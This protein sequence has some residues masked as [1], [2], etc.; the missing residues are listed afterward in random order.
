MKM[1]LTIFGRILAFMPR[2]FPE[3]L[4]GAMGWI[5]ASFPT[6]RRRGLRANLR[7]CFPEYDNKTIHKMAVKSATRTIE[8]GMY[9]LASPYI[10]LETQ[11]KCISV[12]DFVREHVK[13]NSENPQ[14]IIL[15]V[16]HFC[17]AEAITLFPVLTDSKIPRTGVFYRPFD[18]AGIEA[19]VKTTR[20]RHGINLLSR[21][22]GLLIAVNYLKNND[23]ISISYD[24][25]SGFNGT[26]SFFFD[27]LCSS[28]E[29][30][31]MLGERMKCKIGV[32]YAKRTGFW[33]AH[34]DGEFINSNTAEDILIESNLWLENK[35]KSD[36]DL[37]CDWLWLHK[38]W[39][40]L[41]SPKSHFRIKFRHSAISDYLKY[42]NLTEL[43]RKTDFII[44][45]PRKPEDLMDFLPV[46]KA[47][48]AGRA[49]ARFTGLAD[50]KHIKFLESLNIFERLESFPE[51]KDKNLSA[52]LKELNERY[53]HC[54]IV[55]E[56]SEFDDYV[57]KKIRAD[58]RFAVQEE[59]KRKP[60]NRIFQA[61]KEW[62]DAKS[63][64]QKYR[65]FLE[66]FGLQAPSDFTPLSPEAQTVYETLK[67][68]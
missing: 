64:N 24:Q 38:R 28:S 19:W 31:G 11:K 22:D 58:F 52:K 30:A 53:F 23:C 15:L 32:F 27:R 48:R 36:M 51:A 50:A 43:P 49:D 33:K 54:H 44:S 56:D 17:M 65:L 10:S 57:A 60:F 41:I 6:S 34:I 55:C 5:L 66:N 4:S 29:L 47:L 13:R 21:K 18:N 14:A 42:R 63:K 40:V 26:L 59:R 62:K 20:E 25:S 8:M 3:L 68:I 61:T 67:N 9:V 45:L 16:P 7:R 2:K 39:N 46:Y 37:A 12:S 35:L 1:L